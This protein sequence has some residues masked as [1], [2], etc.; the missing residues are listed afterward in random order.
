MAFARLARQ[1][2]AASV[3][4]CAA[5]SAHAQDRLTE[6]LVPET[7]PYPYAILDIQPGA[8]ATEAASMFGERMMLIMEPEQVALRVESGEGR[9]FALTFDQK[10]VT[11]G[12]GLHTRMGQAPF[13]DMQATL[14]T[15]AMGGRVLSIQRTFREP[16]DNLP[17]P[18][19]ILAQLEGLYGPPSKRTTEGAAWAW[20]EDGFIPDLD[21]QPVQELNTIDSNNNSRTTQHRPCTGYNGDAEYNFRQHRETTIAPGCVALFSFIYRGGA[22]L[23]TVSF[24][25]TDFDLVRQHVAEVDRQVIEALTS[26][27][28][29]A[30]SNLD[31]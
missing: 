9:A 24:S 12:V 22:Q 15:E 4:S 7:R 5:V 18:A 17:E 28:A 25:L 31:L 19:A 29:V 16:N 13:A 20:G 26:E 3:V 8:E 14:A 1:L 6:T 30:P 2:L 21:D 10:L 11:Q 23:S 27:N